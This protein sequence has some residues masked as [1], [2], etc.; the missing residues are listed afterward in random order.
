VRALQRPLIEPARFASTQ[1]RNDE[2]RVGI[3]RDAIKSSDNTW[4]RARNAS[5]FRQIAPPA[6]AWIYFAFAIESL[7]FSACSAY[8]FWDKLGFDFL[9]SH[10]PA[11]KL[12]PNHM[13]ARV[14]CSPPDTRAESVH[15]LALPNIEA[16][17][18]VELVHFPPVF[19]L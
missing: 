14:Y 8:L 11:S 12:A 2:N 1:K 15:S 3:S 6:A 7:S 19:S 10:R 5:R 18:L 4:L 9:G 13:R 17:L 16:N